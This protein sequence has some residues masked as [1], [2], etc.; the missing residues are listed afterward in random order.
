MFGKVLFH[1]VLTLL[2]PLSTSGLV[3][4]AQDGLVDV[5]YRR[6][7][8]LV[9]ELAKF[10]GPEQ[11]VPGEGNTFVIAVLGKDPFEGVDEARQ[12]VNHLKAMAQAKKTFNGI[13]LVIRHFDSAKDIQP[14][15]ILFV[16]ALAAE[17]SEERKPEERLKAAV[18]KTKGSPVVLVGD[19]KEFAQKGAVINFFLA[20]SA[21]S[22]LTVK[23][24]I[25]PDAAIR[26]G[27]KV[28]PRIYRLATIV[29]DSA[30]ST[31]PEAK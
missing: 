9:Y 24:E 7:A 16:S 31:G 4:A 8:A 18:E 1:S 28:D 20:P 30:E 15:H 13:K 2:I 14:C 11:I 10:V 19:A 27:L 23:F 12:P 22:E 25:N 5:Q 26:A 21:G 29:R 3:A 17:K 6:K